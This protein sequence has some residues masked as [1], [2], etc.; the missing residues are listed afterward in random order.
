VRK[1]ADR[2]VMLYPLAR[3]NPDEAQ[4]IYDGPTDGLATSE[5]ARV[6][7]FVAGDSRDRSND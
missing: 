1:V 2:V 6:R 3:L 4:I 7:E 5:D